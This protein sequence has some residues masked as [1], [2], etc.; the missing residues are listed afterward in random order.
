MELIELFKVPLFV[1]LLELDVESI[2]S[3]CLDYKKNNEGRIVSNVGGYQSDDFDIPELEKEIMACV[4]AF[5]K[6]FGVE[7]ELVL[8]AKW[9]NING[10]NN[11]NNIHCHPGS[12]I[13]GVY[14]VQVP[15]KSGNIV[16]D[17]PSSDVMIH[18]HEGIN[19]NGWNSFNSTKYWQEAKV[20]ILYLFPGWLK[21]RVEP[22]LSNEERIS[23]SFNTA[24]SLG[25]S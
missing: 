1:A 10:P 17:N 7:D 15:C 24:V 13:S 11:Y 18:N 6:S 21:H 2:K 14:Y 16:F 12:L 19:F 5:A 20:G 23:I 8:D 4:N 22:N 9:F 3:Y 25:W